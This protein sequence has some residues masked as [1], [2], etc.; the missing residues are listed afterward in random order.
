LSQT[1]ILNN[2]DSGGDM[3]VKLA[4]GEA[5]VISD[6]RKYFLDHGVDIN[7]LESAT[8]GSNASKRSNNTLLI[9]NLP[10]NLIEAELEAMFTR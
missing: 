4:M 6:N 3:A 5:A 1:E 10:P 2:A 7:A 8:S 9:K